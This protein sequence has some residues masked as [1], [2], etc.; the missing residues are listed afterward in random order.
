[1]TLNE[2]IEKKEKKEKLARKMSAYYR[3]R[4]MLIKEM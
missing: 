3:E 2:W 1:M 4:N